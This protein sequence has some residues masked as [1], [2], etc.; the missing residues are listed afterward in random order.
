MLLCSRVLRF[1][2]CLAVWMGP[3][4]K[5]SY[6]GRIASACFLRATVDDFPADFIVV[7]QFDQN[8]SVDREFQLGRDTQASPRNVANQDRHAVPLS[9][10]QQCGR[11]LGID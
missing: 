3:D 2:L 1:L 6:T 5:N 11:E 4:F 8:S 7:V 9:N 10:T